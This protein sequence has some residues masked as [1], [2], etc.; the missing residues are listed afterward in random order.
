MDFSC[1]DGERDL[2]KDKPN[3]KRDQPPA[4]AHG[5]SLWGVALSLRGS[6]SARTHY[7]IRYSC[8]SRAHVGAWTYDAS[9]RVRSLLRDATAELTALGACHVDILAKSETTYF[10]HPAKSE[11]TYFG[12]PLSMRAAC[13]PVMLA[14]GGAVGYWRRRENLLLCGVEFSRVRAHNRLIRRDGN[15]WLRQIW[16]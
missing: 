9:R 3:R 13:A 14:G 8:H 12:F 16:F 7:A 4:P 11:R 10:E 1:A 5:V 6:I 2:R 15:S